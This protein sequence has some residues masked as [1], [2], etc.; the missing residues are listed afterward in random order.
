MRSPTVSG[1]P[2]PDLN[3]YQEDKKGNLVAI[4]DD[5][6]HTIHVLLSHGQTLSV[7][8][9]WYQMTIINVQANDYGNYKCEGS[10]RMGTHLGTVLLYGEC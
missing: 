9:V 10:N 6:K 5:E 3:W 2:L 7:A 4:K 1:Y 8:E